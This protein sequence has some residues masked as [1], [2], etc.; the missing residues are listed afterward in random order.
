MSTRADPNVWAALLDSYLPE[1]LRYDQTDLI[2]DVS[3]DRNIRDIQDVPLILEQARENLLNSPDLLSYLAIHQKRWKAVVWLVKSILDHHMDM[4]EADKDC[5][6]R[7]AP[8]WPDFGMSFDDLTYDPFWADGIIRPLESATLDHDRLGEQPCQSVDVKKAS[9]GQLWQSIA[10]MILHAADCPEGNPETRIIMTHVLQILAQMSNVNA[11][12]DSIYIP[13][14]VEDGVTIQ[15]PPTLNLLSSRIAAMLSDT[16]RRAHKLETTSNPKYVRAKHSYTSV[17]SSGDFQESHLREISTSVWLDLVLW[18]CIEGGWITEAVWIAA[19]IDR[20]SLDKE[21]S[22][23]VIRWDSLKQQ[24][25]LQL[26]TDQITEVPT[27]AHHGRESLLVNVPPRAISREVVLALLD[28]L[29]NTTNPIGS[30][31]NVA[32]TFSQDIGTCKRLLAT[33]GF[34]IGRYVLNYL[35]VRLV[36]SNAAM[37]EPKKLVR[38]LALWPSHSEEIE[39]ISQSQISANNYVHELG[40]ANSAIWISLFHNNLFLFA[41]SGDIDNTL[42]CFYEFQCFMDDYSSQLI[43]DFVENRTIEDNSS[44]STVETSSSIFLSQIPIHVQRRLLSVVLH[45]KLFEFGKWLL[46]SNEAD[47]TTIPPESYSH[48]SLQ[49]VLLNFA[50]A[51]ADTQLQVQL[52]EKLSKPL[53][54]P[55]LRALLHCQIEFGKWDSVERLLLYLRDHQTALWQHRAAM[56]IARAILLMEKDSFNQSSTQSH[57]IENAFGLLQKYFAGDFNRYDASDSYSNRFMHLRTLNQVFRILKN[58]SGILSNLTSPYSAKPGPANSPIR[59][60][61]QAFNDLIDGV[62]ERDGSATGKELWDM[63][64]ENT[65]REGS[66]SLATL[67]SAVIPNLQTIRTILRPII[68]AKR[69]TERVQA[70]NRKSQNEAKLGIQQKRKQKRDKSKLGAQQNHKQSYGYQPENGEIVD[71]K[72]DRRIVQWACEVFKT[73][74]GLSSEEIRNEFPDNGAPDMKPSATSAAVSASSLPETRTERLASNER[75]L[76]GNILKFSKRSSKA[77]AV[78]VYLNLTPFRVNEAPGASS[79]SSSQLLSDQIL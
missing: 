79:T 8:F 58:C 69:D 55:V 77:Q 73:H 74:F 70:N 4:P 64:C 62:V 63:W 26:S 72:S 37:D 45:A 51:T 34:G 40:I 28:C 52:T 78:R 41:M 17:D 49:P 50:A 22:W 35:M 67:E 1:G 23:S 47:G 10:C 36:E 24:A 42:R 53:T 71:Q 9:L 66:A 13:R 68:E 12:P 6:E 46:Y 11:I 33:E 5:H 38:I 48:P 65:D 31:N 61:T 59:I 14:Q 57:S 75:A 21:R 30:A 27:L 7:Q 76:F 19:E 2:K 60:D 16:A 44:E 3:R 54:P 29:A 15:Q 20:R 18:S 56:R 25:I 32:E 43:K 39:P